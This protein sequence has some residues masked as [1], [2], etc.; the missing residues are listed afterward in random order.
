M[1]T[2]IYMSI[3]IYTGIVVERLISITYTVFM[4]RLP[5]ELTCNVTRVVAWRVNNKYYTLTDLANGALP[6]HD[7][8]ET[9]VLV[10]RPQINNTE[11][12]CVSITNDG[13]VSGDPAY[14]II[15]GE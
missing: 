8:N 7:R 10:Y 5:I 4:T 1:C 9:N 3:Y 14:I 12:V 13:D 15:I 11:Y 2:T 6:A